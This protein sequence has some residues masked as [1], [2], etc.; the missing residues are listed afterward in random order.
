[1]IAGRSVHNQRIER[2]WRDLFAGC[3]SFFYNFF[4]YLEDIGM[5][6]INDPLDIYSLH[7]VALPVL[8]HH[9]DLFQE[10]W[11]NH[12][13]RTEGNKTPQQLW[14]LGLHTAQSA[15]HNDDAVVGLESSSVVR[16]CYSC[17]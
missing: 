15:D 7:I 10:A 3:V 9:L 8:Q 5:L 17:D 2:L 14:I 1:M 6:D 11:A 12:R 16:L 4:F 13:L